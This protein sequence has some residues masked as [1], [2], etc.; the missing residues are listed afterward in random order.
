M[1]FSSLALVSGVVSMAQAYER[2]VKM[3]AP[4]V[5]AYHQPFNVT[6]TIETSPRGFTKSVG[7]IISGLPSEYDNN[8]QS[9][10]GYLTFIDVSSKYCIYLPLIASAFYLGLWRMMMMMMMMLISLQTP[11]PERTSTR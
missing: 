6:Y 7:L 5:V 2:V 1:K 10:G 11:S 3:T 8:P 4:N 9:I